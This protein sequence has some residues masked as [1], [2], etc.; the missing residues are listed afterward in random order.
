MDKSEW[1]SE[2]KLARLRSEGLVP[3]SRFS[4]ACFVGLL[5]VASIFLVRSKSSEFISAYLGLISSDLNSL[6]SS[7]AEV[8]LLS[9]LVFGGL[10]AFALALLVLP[11]VLGLF[12]TKFFFRP[13]NL[14]FDLRRMLPR[15]GTFG[16]GVGRV[17][18][19][20]TLPFLLLIVPIALALIAIPRLFLLLN[21]DLNTFLSWLGENGSSFAPFLSGFLAVAAALGWIVSRYKF[22]LKHRMTRA[23]VEAE[24]RERD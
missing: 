8:A 12:Q 9:D 20:L 15:I 13:A 23:E 2:T 5:V 1:P 14:S 22:M 17:G 18:L 6:S 4:S 19:K 3:F 16:A 7:G 24:A 21:R 11:M 10:V